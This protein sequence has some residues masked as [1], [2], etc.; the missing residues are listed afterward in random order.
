[1]NTHTNNAIGYKMLVDCYLCSLPFKVNVGWQLCK[2]NDNA[3]YCNIDIPDI[4][5]CS[6][7]FRLVVNK[8]AK[9]LAFVC[10]DCKVSPYHIDGVD[11]DVLALL[12]SS[13]VV[14][15]HS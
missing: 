7:Q 12:F 2:I 14:C 11:N 15:N 8:Q 9:S 10:E 3:I 4:A 1:M 5:H 13:A 6:G